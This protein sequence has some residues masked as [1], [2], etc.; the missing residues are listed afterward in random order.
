MTN[1]LPLR[2]TPFEEYFLTDDRPGYRMSFVVEL[3]FDG[4]IDRE[5]FEASLAEATLR[6]PLFQAL[7]ERRRWGRLWWIPAEIAP[8]VDWAAIDQPVNFSSDPGFDLT[9]EVGIRFFSRVGEGRSSVIVQI[10]H[11]CCDGIGAIQFLSDLFAAYVRRLLPAGSET[12]RLQPVQLSQLHQRNNLSMSCD[13]TWTPWRLRMKL[14]RDTWVHAAHP[15]PVPLAAP[16]K[17]G[18]PLPYPGTLTRTLHDQAHVQLRQMARRHGVTLNELLVRELLL[19]NRDWNQRCG[20][21]QPDDWLAVLIPSNARNLIHDGM[22]AANVMGYVAFRRNAADCLSSDKLLESIREESQFFKRTRYAVAFVD[23]INTAARI[24]GLLRRIAHQPRCAATSVLSCLGDP[25]RA[26][27]A[28]YPVNSDGNPIMANIVLTGVNT[29]P[30]IRPLTRAAF[31]SWHFSNKQRL[32]VRCDPAAFST[33]QAQA[34]LDLFADRVASLA[35]SAEGHR[36]I[37]RA[38]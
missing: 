27:A 12:P 37:P 17:L 9:R 36:N 8:P 35:A 38:A 24:P 15:K 10:H 16:A 14:L 28:N 19:A 13:A 32:G 21:H 5:A 18:T 29:A 1:V 11:S 6:H 33:E 31:T 26:I 30:P 25:S 34:L 2:V 22:P 23:G 7:I 3:T 4:E 20:T